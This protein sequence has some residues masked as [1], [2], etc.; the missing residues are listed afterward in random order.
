MV[1]EWTK[2]SSLQRSLRRST[3]VVRSDAS[4]LAAIDR[5]GLGGSAMLKRAQCT[6]YFA[7]E[8]TR[9]GKDSELASTLAQGKPVIAYVPEGETSMSTIWGRAQTFE[10]RR[11]EVDLLLEQLRVFEPPAAWKDAE[12]GVGC[13]TGAGHREEVARSPQ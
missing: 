3:F 2:R 5:Q 10:P 8:S 11:G 12:S 1:H 9:Y 4:V 6:L 13:L 7:Q